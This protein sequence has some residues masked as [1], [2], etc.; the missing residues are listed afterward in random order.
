MLLA[1]NC[2]SIPVNCSHISLLTLGT[3][4]PADGR[5]VLVIGLTILALGWCRYMREY[6]AGNNSDVWTQPSIPQI[7]W[8]RGSLECT[9]QRWLNTTVVEAA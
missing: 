4:T 8:K 9:E 2:T 6:S 1:Q 3:C 5:W 7:T